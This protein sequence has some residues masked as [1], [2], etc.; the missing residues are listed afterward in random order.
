MSAKIIEILIMEGIA[1]LLFLCAYLIGVKG[2][3][4]LIAGYNERT[5]EKV[6]DK[7]GLK[8]L[9]T[10]L[11]VLVGAAAALMPLLSSLVGE[12]S[13]SMF[14]LIGGFGGFIVGLVA[15]VMLQARDYTE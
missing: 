8:R 15:M 3:M 4:N 6:R 12:Q 9:I 7:E 13:R 11:C 1:A 14:Y 10:R 2:H 5:A